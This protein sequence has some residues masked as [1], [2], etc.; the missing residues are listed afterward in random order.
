MSYSTSVLIKV[1]T[2]GV[3]FVSR[4]VWRRRVSYSS[5]IEVPTNR[6]ETEFDYHRNYQVLGPLYLQIINLHLSSDN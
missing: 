1:A 5:L 4:T 3:W 2:E 6:N